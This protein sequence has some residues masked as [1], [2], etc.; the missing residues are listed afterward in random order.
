MNVIS[1]FKTTGGLL[2]ILLMA[3]AA[4][5]SAWA[6]SIERLTINYIETAAVPEKG[7]NEVRAYVTVSD[8][9]DHPVPGL[10][11]S[12]FEMLQD[13]TR[14][15]I[16][17]A[18]PST[19]PMAV[20]L[21]IDTSGS[22]QARDKSGQTSMAAAKKAAIDFISM[23]SENDRVAIFSFSNDAHL[24]MDFSTD[25][26]AAIEAVGHLTAKPHGATRLYDTA[27][28]AVKK[29][30]EIPKGRRAVILLTDGRDEKSGGKCSVRSVGDL[31]DA[32]TTRAIRVPVYTIGVGPR[33]DA[34]ELARIAGLTGGRSLMATTLEDLPRFY[35]TIANQLKNQ[36]RVTFISRVPSGEHSLVVKV[37][38]EGTAAQD[39]KTF[40]SPPLPV[41]PPPTVRI[42]APEG[43]GVVHGT[44]TLRLDI[45][46]AENIARMR[47]Y[48]D[49]ALEREQREPPFDRFIWDT[50]GLTPG[51]HVVRVEII[52][53]AGRSSSAEMTAKIKG[54]PAPRPSTARTNAPT[55]VPAHGKGIRPV[56]IWA[57]AA[58]L[59]LILIICC[60]IWRPGRK[61][62]GEE[63]GESSSAPGPSEEPG[64]KGQEPP[65]TIDTDETQFMPDFGSTEETVIAGDVDR[66]PL[67]KIT[68]IESM[69]LDP[70]KTFD[71]GRGTTTVGRAS[72]NDIF[73]PDKP[74]SRKHAEISY[75]GTDFY[76]RDLGSK[77]GTQ[78]DGESVSTAPIRLEDGARIQ[79]STKTVLQFTLIESRSEEV[80]SED[81]GSVGEDD[82]T[83]VYDE[84]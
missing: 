31:I 63:P 50:A 42:T 24:R 79:L 55:A 8:R 75:D 48:V 20:V 76:I 21:A 66:T 56:M 73:V 33:V 29:A 7:A 52:D 18:A 46:P 72:G 6:G 44:V 38:Q 17:E 53:R 51:L 11:A 40:W 62:K 5:T 9:D 45:Q 70:G 27:I 10:A 26:A 34:R 2:A 41:L 84:D 28:L 49:G 3:T 43:S 25:H 32:A 39:E 19:D 35:Q 59:L 61:R 67:A 1:R 81:D 13:G 30:A 54:L 74:V 23:L 37:R 64:I 47:C 68:I 77:N 16:E 36:Y 71:V 58:V 65:R 14:V 15:R 22:M 83:R 80:A 4:L 69:N 78:V 12:D 57:G 82:V 60:L